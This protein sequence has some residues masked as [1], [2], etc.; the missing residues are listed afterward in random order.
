MGRGAEGERQNPEAVSPLSV[1]PNT[2]L[3]PRTLTPP[4][5]KA[6]VGRPTNFTTQAPLIILSL[7]LEKLGL[8]E[9]KYFL[10]VTEPVCGIERPYLLKNN[11]YFIPS[12]NVLPAE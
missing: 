4:E 2:G 7:Q 11:L 12:C 8:R 1:E 5:P 9:V 6:R 10:K 3:D